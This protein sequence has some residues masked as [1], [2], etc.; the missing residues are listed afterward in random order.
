MSSTDFA[1]WLRNELIERN[2]SPADLSRMMKKK[3]ASIS[4]VLN[5][6]RAAG[7]DF[8]LAVATALRLPPEELYRIAGLLPRKPVRQGKQEMLLHELAALLEQMSPNSQQM[9]I[10]LVREIYEHDKETQEKQGN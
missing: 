1:N 3:P 7:T 5:E 10:K 2:I 6:K 9:V 4:N 8:I